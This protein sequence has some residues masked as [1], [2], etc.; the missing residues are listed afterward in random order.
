MHVPRL[1]I[2]SAVLCLACG[3]SSPRS[4]RANAAHDGVRGIIQIFP[5]GHGSGSLRTA[6]GECYDLA[7]PPKVLEAHRKWNAHQVEVTGK[8]I[9]RP[10]LP[11]ASWY[12][13]RDR[14]IEAG[15]CSNRVIYV[16]TIFKV[17]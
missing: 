16:M 12:D 2:I 1:L 17:S 10:H 5:G 7:L 3:C 14:R 6:E 4:L 11:D 13:I 15:G 8:V 9:V